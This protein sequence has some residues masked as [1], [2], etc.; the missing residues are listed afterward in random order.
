MALK[1]DKIRKKPNTFNRLFGVSVLQF[2]GIL[3]KVEPL[4]QKQVIGH[5]KR[6]GRFHKLE[7]S[8]MLL[9]LL[10]L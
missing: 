9:M 6:P 8:E 5:Y 7:V 10:L 1:Y 4:W 2:E 3:Q